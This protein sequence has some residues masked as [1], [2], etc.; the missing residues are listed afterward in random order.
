MDELSIKVTI[1]N[2][3]YPLKIKR[4]DEERVRKAAKMVNDRIREY[5]QQYSVSDKIDLIAMCAMQF[6]TELV[7]TTESQ[8]E[9]R[10]QLSNEITSIDKVLSDYISKVNVH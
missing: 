6:A 10:Q 7:N 1:A 2:R 4:A 5:E 3:I 8:E 9:E